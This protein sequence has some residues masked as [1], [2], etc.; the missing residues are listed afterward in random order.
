MPTT[1]LLHAAPEL[2]ERRRGE[3]REDESRRA[4]GF[5]S[6]T[7][8][9]RSATA[10]LLL[11]QAVA[12]VTGSRA[13]RA[14]TSRWCR[15]CGTTGDHGRPV[16]VGADGA[17]LAGV[18]LSASH[19][20]GSVLVAAST[21]APVG[22]D[23][24]LV[25]GVRFT[26][27]DE[28]ALTPRERT[29]LRSLPPAERDAWRARAWTRKESLLKATGHGLAVAPVRVGFEG[30]RL[31]EW[32]P[33]LDPDV[34][35]GAVVVDVATLDAAAVPAGHVASLTVLSRVPAQV[36]VRAAG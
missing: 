28:A 11:R 22:V 29:A 26:G 20:G 9:A 10:A 12:E 8:R 18:H 2:G 25:G 7:D 32:P 31:R 30:D 3:L 36:L 15:T 35:G 17:V 16:A 23:V 24:E 34:A 1:L 13:A 14:R 5:R 27:F 33:A 4:G 19:A 6:P 21:G